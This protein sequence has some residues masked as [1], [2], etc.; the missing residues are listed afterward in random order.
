MKLYNSNEYRATKQWPYAISAG[1][2]VYRINNGTVEIL[3]LLRKA[4][5]FPQL[6]DGNI[7]SYH[8]PKGHMNIGETLEQTATRETAEEAGVSVE[9]TTYLGARIFDH[10]HLKMKQSKTIHYFAGLWQKDLESMD[11]EH[12]SKLWVN[13]D[14][15]LRLLGAPNPKREDERIK[16][17]ITFLELSNAT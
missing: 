10:T 17:L 7:D 6:K 1:C 16:A 2:V 11:A 9:I 14:D 5:D 4:G 12:T 3:L 8:L 13:V 15:A